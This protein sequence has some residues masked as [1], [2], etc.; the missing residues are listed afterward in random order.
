MFII[1]GIGLYYVV[2][3]QTC[4]TEPIVANNLL[5]SLYI[6]IK[7]WIRNIIIWDC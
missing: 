3:G 6:R 7:H 2:T 4:Q 1:I 5:V